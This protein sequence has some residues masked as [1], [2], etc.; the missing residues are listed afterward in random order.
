MIIFRLGID[1]IFYPFLDNPVNCSNKPGVSTNKHCCALLSLFKATS[2]ASALIIELVMFYSG[3]L[4]RPPV[5]FELVWRRD[6]CFA[7]LEG[8]VIFLY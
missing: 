6:T 5:H 1:F 2:S 3:D 4:R 7:V 8:S